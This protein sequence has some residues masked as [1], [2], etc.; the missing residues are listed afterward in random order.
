VTEA[1]E[2]VGGVSARIFDDWSPKPVMDAQE[3][4]KPMTKGTLNVRDHW[5]FICY[6]VA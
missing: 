3:A 5:N 1:Q 6:K 4:S 2:P